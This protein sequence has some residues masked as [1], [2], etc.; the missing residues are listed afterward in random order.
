ML[1]VDH[2]AE[3]FLPGGYGERELKAGCGLKPRN[4]HGT[5]APRDN[6]AAVNIERLNVRASAAQ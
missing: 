4:T 5:L 6:H 2:H 3:S 1:S